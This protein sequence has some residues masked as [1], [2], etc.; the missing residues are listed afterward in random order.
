MGA[1]SG[2]TTGV[3][4]VQVIIDNPS[5]VAYELEHHPGMDFYVQALTTHVPPCAA[6]H[7]D[8]CQPDPY[9]PGQSF[10]AGQLAL[11]VR[12]PDYGWQPFPEQL[13]LAP[14]S[15]SHP[16]A[17]YPDC[18]L[19]GP[20]VGAPL[21]GSVTSGVTDSNGNV[22]M[23]EEGGY[24]TYAPTLSGAGDGHASDECDNPLRAGDGWADLGLTCQDSY[25]NYMGD[26]GFPGLEYGN[27]IASRDAFLRPG[28][29]YYDSA[30][31]LV[32]IDVHVGGGTRIVGYDPG[33]QLVTID[34]GANFQGSRTWTT[35]LSVPLSDVCVR[36]PVSASQVP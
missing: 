29:M 5:Y 14:Q 12:P 8:W 6:T 13:P 23:V 18:P 10:A 21:P 3:P 9:T 34:I 1:N 7:P 4:G 15:L 30:P 24:F 32:M 2:T 11:Y 17:T 20:Y 26:D 35:R 36:A 22:M 28:G 16:C 27:K 33:T 31:E 19:T 25:Y